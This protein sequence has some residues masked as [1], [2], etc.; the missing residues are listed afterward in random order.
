MRLD[1][2]LPPGRWVD[3]DTLA[4]N[5]LKGLRDAGVLQ[6]RYAGL[7]AILVTKREDAPTGVD[8]RPV[9]A[10]TVVG[11]AQPGP[12]RLDVTAPLLPRAGRPDVK[13]AWR[14]VLAHAWGDSP[15]LQGALWADVSMPVAGPLIAPLEVVLDA[16]EPV[17]GRDPRGRAWQEFFPNDHLIT[18]LRVLRSDLGAGLR[19]QLGPMAPSS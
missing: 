2:V 17:L 10:G 1:F 13:R 4:E 16:L 15:P 3:V 9:G 6:P 7:D 5:T 11:C 8:V 12:P 14:E 19:L 18:W